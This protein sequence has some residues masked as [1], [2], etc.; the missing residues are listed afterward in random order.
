MNIIFISP[1]YPAGHRRYVTALRQAGHCVYGIGDAGEETF[2]P[3]LR[4]ALNAYYR[5]GDLHD[6]DSVYRACCYYTW[7]FGR[8]DA[9]ESLNPYWRDLVSALKKD[10]VI[11]AHS[12]EQEL[13]KLE[14]GLDCGAM[15]PRMRAASPK[16]VCTFAAE[17]GYPLLAVPTG[18]KRLGSRLV[19]A[20]A[21]VKSLLRGSTKDEYVFAVS[22]EGEPLWVDGL[23]LG[24]KIV[25]CAAHRRAADG[26]SVACVPIDGLEQRCAE[27]AAG[28]GH[29][30]GFFHI[31]AVELT[32]A[33]K[34]TGKKGDVFFVAFEPVPPHEYIV[35]LMDIEFGC[36]LR[37]SW[38]EGCAVLRNAEPCEGWSESAAGTAEEPSVQPQ[39][40][41]LL[42][43]ER[44]CLAAAACRSFERSYKNLHEKIL[45]R[46]TTRLAFHGRTEEADRGEY[47]DYIYLF[48][49]ETA[50]ELKKSIRFITEDH[51][52]PDTKSSEE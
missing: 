15:T 43:L 35:D 44:R 9:I 3:E 45:R 37:Q 48:S 24:G 36:D 2:A 14:Y 28:F 13:G 26:Q 40:E 47:S 23:M 27:A 1:N 38:A 30:D 11:P 7:Q 51:P 50:A 25:A 19:A 22:P 18:N 4:G 46:L 52:L 17:H 8:M 6:Y 20:D 49:G 34:G 33:V 21:G 42:P 31:H 32:A 10:V 41:T 39:T 12:P 16:K 29:T 5:V